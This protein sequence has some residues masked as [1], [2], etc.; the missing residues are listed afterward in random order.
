MSSCNLCVRVFVAVQASGWM[1]LLRGIG[2][3]ASIVH[4]ISAVHGTG[5]SS[6]SPRCMYLASLLTKS[7]P[8]HLI[9]LTY[10]YLLMFK[11]TLHPSCQP[12]LEEKII[13]DEK[14]SR[15]SPPDSDKSKGCDISLAMAPLPIPL[16]LGFGGKY[17][18]HMHIRDSNLEWTYLQP[19]LINIK[20]L[21]WCKYWNI[22]N[23]VFLFIFV[24]FFFFDLLL[25]NTYII[26][27]FFIY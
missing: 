5:A 4:E 6:S 12:P 22:I 3:V 27:V 26:N 7:L 16:P 25:Q 11:S 21:G 9:L 13:E 15:K 20:S 24:C 14:P 17:P 2:H 19:K 10:T 8:S 23:V 18:P 1:R